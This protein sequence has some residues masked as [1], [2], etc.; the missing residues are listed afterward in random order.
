MTSLTIH[1]ASAPFAPRAVLHDFDAIRAAVAA[2]GTLLERWPLVD[3]AGAVSDKAILAAYAPRIAQLQARGGYRSHDVVRMVPD[4]P[5]RADLRAKFL[6]E[7]VHEDDEVRFFVEGSGLF[8]IHHAGQIHALDCTA[9]DLIVLPA[10]THHWFDSG[11]APRFTAIRL[12][13][14]P[15]G[16]VAHYTGATLATGL[17]AYEGPR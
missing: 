13:T 15:E 12:F 11:A 10:G 16:W 3:L 9:G 17:P 5:A 2:S 7:H 1:E 14:S 8:C 4:H 6:A